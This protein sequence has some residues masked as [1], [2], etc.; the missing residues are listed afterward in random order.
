MKGDKGASLLVAFSPDGQ[1]IASCNQNHNIQLYKVDTAECVN[2]L[3]GHKSLINSITFCPDNY[4]LVS[5]S[6]DETIKFWDSIS[7]ECTRTLK[8]EKPYDDMNFMGV[9]GLTEGRIISL[10]ALGAVGS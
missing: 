4:T 3:Q 8:I 10:K 7:G 6:E 9:T 5:S 1:V 2:V